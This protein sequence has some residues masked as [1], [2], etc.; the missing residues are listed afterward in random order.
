MP[1]AVSEV[2]SSLDEYIEETG[3]TNDTPIGNFQTHI[4]QGDGH[5]RAQVNKNTGLPELFFV[6]QIDEG[7]QNAR[8]TIPSNIRWFVP[9]TNAQGEAYDDD[10]RKQM[11]G[12]N[13]QQFRE[14]MQ[15]VFGKQFENYDYGILPESGD[16]EEE[17]LEV[18]TAI[19][20]E[21]GGKSVEVRTSKNKKN[22]QYTNL[23]FAPAKDD[24][25]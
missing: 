19:S 25:F 23:R 9:E 6:A 12:M 21:L 4:M 16:S 1:K 15:A 7:Q 8:R 20:K 5:P 2:L 10:K 13:R 22:P 3:G 14:F 17:I 11:E 24:T 18:F